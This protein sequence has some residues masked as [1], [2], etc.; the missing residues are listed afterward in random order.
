MN[1]SKMG[2]LPA[3]VVFLV[4]AYLPWCD[5]IRARRVCHQWKTMIESSAELLYLVELD[6]ASSQNSCYLDH[7]SDLDRASFVQ[8]QTAWRALSFKPVSQGSLRG[9]KFTLSSNGVLASAKTS[10]DG[11]ITTFTRNSLPTC[12]AG[13]K[14]PSDAGLGDTL[15][16]WCTS[17]LALEPELVS[18][19][20]WNEETDLL[21]LTRS[22]APFEFSHS[23][24]HQC[25]A[26]LVADTCPSKSQAL[27]YTQL[28]LPAAS[29]ML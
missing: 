23:V 3:E 28:H 15:S 27:T 11:K 6:I 26:M 12:R 5:I 29:R 25:F 9:D 19:S 7:A 14:P 18:Q 13:S 8:R 21:M 10:Q 1:L 4:L 20:L 24:Y 16:S 17:T 2:V 22:Y